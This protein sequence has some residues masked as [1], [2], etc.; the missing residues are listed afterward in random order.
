MII[1]ERFVWLHFPK[2]AGTEIEN[3]LRRHFNED[4][5]FHF[6]EID[7]RNV[8]WHQNIDERKRL[9]PGFDISGRD[10]ICAFRRL[11]HWLLSRVHFEK[12]RN[13]EI[14]V[15]REMFVRGQFFEN[16]NLVIAA[17]YYAKKY[18][19]V[20]VNRWIRTEHAR[21]DFEAVF[22]EY[23]DL[24][25]INLDKEMQKKNAN[26][27]GYINDIEFY[28]TS[29][30]LKNLYDMNPVWRDLEREVYGDILSI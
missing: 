19:T 17:D 5:N 1:G 30:E 14:V 29:G 3:I 26:R 15:T 22:S 9:D 27:F 24:S 8:I 20:P 4:K 6:D 12:G 21:S 10:V 13:P 23:L 11:P 16:A 25:N 18:T 7:P 28:F 2:C